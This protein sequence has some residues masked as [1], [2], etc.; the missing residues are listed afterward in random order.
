MEQVEWMERIKD[1]KYLQ[2]SKIRESSGM[3]TE[4]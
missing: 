4:H 3:Y 1:F 2:S